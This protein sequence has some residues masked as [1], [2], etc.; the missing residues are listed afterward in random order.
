MRT[1]IDLPD[2]LLRTLKEIAR[3]RNQTLSQAVVDAMRRSMAPTGPG[4][5]IEMNPITGLPLIYLGRPTTLED[6]RALD[7]D[8]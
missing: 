5:K 3:D 7:D 6:V 8:E 1:T 4:A 2:D